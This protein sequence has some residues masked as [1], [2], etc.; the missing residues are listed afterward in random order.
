MTIVNYS[1]HKE[2]IELHESHRQS[3]ANFASPLLSQFNISWFGYIRLFPNGERMILNTNQDWLKQYI[4]QDLHNDHIHTMNIE[5]DQ[6]APDK[7]VYYSLWSGLSESKSF[8]VLYNKNVFN[9]LY[10]YRKRKAGS[11]VFSFATSVDNTSANDF[12]LNNLSF[13]NY[14]SLLFKDKFSHIIN[15]LNEKIAISPTT[16]LDISSNT[17]FTIDEKLTSFY[18]KT[19]IK[20]LF[21]NAKPYVY[22]TKQEC[23]CLDLLSKG[24]TEKEAALAL[25]LSIRTVESYLNNLKL[26]LGCQYKSQLL[27]IYSQGFHI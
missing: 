12:Y 3:M 6:L 5:I 20:R 22:A 23:L 9:G 15:N 13:F 18:Q 27:E 16:S 7:K 2:A 21:F 19:E 14:V 11:E 26:K 4:E 10:I 24:F 17:G 1:Q 8:N 25:N